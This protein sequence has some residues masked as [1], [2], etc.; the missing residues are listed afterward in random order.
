MRASCAGCSTRNM[1]RLDHIVLAAVTIEEG[2]NYVEN[3]LGVGLETGGEH[4]LFGTHNRLLGLG[5]CYFEV[6]ARN[7][8]AAPAKRSLWFDLERFSGHPRVITWVCQTS[9]MAGCL[10][11]LPYNP[12][13]II[14]VTRDD[15]VWDLT[16]AEDGRMAMDGM[17]PSIIDWRNIVPPPQSL[18]DAGCKLKY[19]T[20]SH[21]QAAQLSEWAEHSLQDPR[22]AFKT[23][24]DSRITLTLMTPNGDVDL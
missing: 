15:L 20:V 6:I 18:P 3:R 24:E 14:T 5:D 13:P 11:V 9:D 1:E 19:M 17:A 4:V 8:C 10:S 16:I 7:P 2:V 12:G 23:A 22:V 21:A